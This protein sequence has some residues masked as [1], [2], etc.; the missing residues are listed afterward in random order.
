[1]IVEGI[2]GVGCDVVNVVDVAAVVALS[3]GGNGRIR[4]R[5]Q[6]IGLIPSQ[7]VAV[8]EAQTAREAPVHLDDER[9]ILVARSVVARQNLG[10][11]GE[12][13]VLL[14]Q[15]GGG[16]QSGVSVHG[17]AGARIGV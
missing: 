15:R 6:G 9:V 7:G 2:S 1:R 11:V 17:L 12:L 3:A 5:A 13:Q 16:R 10:E 8:G 4:S 14:A